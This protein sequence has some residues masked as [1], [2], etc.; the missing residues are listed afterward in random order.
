MTFCVSVCS[1]SMHSWADTNCPQHTPPAAASPAPHQHQPKALRNKPWYGRTP[2]VG[3]YSGGEYYSQSSLKTAMLYIQH[4]LGNCTHRPEFM[5]S[6]IC[7]AHSLEEYLVIQ[8]VSKYS[9]SSSGCHFS[10]KIKSCYKQL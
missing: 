2:G 9:S 10:D 3:V 6:F 7:S 8:H 5:P 1:Q 4:T